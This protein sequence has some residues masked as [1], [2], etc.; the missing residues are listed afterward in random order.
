MARGRAAPVRPHVPGFAG[1]WIYLN[2]PGNGAVFCACVSKAGLP[3]E[4]GRSRRD[5]LGFRFTGSSLSTVSY[6][7]RVVHAVTQGLAALGVGTPDAAGSGFALPGSGRAA[8]IGLLSNAASAPL[9]SA[10]PVGPGCRC[11]AGR[12]AGFSWFEKGSR[13]VWKQVPRHGYPADKMRGTKRNGFRYLPGADTAVRSIDSDFLATQC[14][15]P[16]GATT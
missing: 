2:G 6:Q 3:G 8:V 1:G 13:W 15:W 12:S 10:I 11:G 5:R 4:S 14:R 9:G 16:A 7:R